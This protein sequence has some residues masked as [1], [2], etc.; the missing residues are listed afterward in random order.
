M[1]FQFCHAETFIFITKLSSM[2]FCTF[3]YKVN[4]LFVMEFFNLTERHLTN[5]VT[6]FLTGYSRI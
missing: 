5:K 3:N 2:S 6:L 4:L 1:L